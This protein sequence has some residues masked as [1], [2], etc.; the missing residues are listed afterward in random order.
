MT[1]SIC[2]YCEATVVAGLQPPR[3]RR[4]A[5]ASEMPPGP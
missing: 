1:W 5:L 4:E 2:P 3:Q